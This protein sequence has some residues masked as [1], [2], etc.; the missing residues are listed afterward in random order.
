MIYDVSDDQ[1]C[2]SLP[3]W[4]L[5]FFLTK[6]CLVSSIYYLGISLCSTFESFQL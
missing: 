6:S 5:Q 1:R 2:D 3:P 4:F